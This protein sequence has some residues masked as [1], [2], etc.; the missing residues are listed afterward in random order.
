MK[1][2]LK[3]ILSSC[4]CIA[5]QLIPQER[6]PEYF[7]KL[8]EIPKQAPSARGLSRIRALAPGTQ[9]VIPSHIPALFPAIP[10]DFAT[11]TLLSPIDRKQATTVQ[12]DIDPP[13]EKGPPEISH[14]PTT[15]ATS[16][17][18]FDSWYDACKS[19]TPNIKL[20][21][22]KPPQKQLVTKKELKLVLQSYNK[23]MTHQLSNAP[24][25]GQPPAPNSLFYVP[26]YPEKDFHNHMPFVQKIVVKPGT[27]I[28]VHGD[29]HGDILSPMAFLN[30]LKN[31]NYLDNNFK[32]IKENFMMLFLGDYT[33]RGN[34]GIENIYTILR[35]KIMNPDKVFL[36]RGNHED[37]SITS[38]YGFMKE[39]EKKYGNDAPEITK[40]IHRIYDFMPV[41]LYLGT[42]DATQDIINFLLCCHG[43]LEPGFYPQRLLLNPESIAYELLP[44][45]LNPEKSIKKLDNTLKE[46]ID[47]ALLKKFA[48]SRS[49]KN[50]YFNIGFMWN[51]FFVA[52]NHVLEYNSGRGWQ[53]GKDIT[54]NLLAAH[55]N[56]QA[57]IRG[58]L[59]AHQHGDLGTSEMMQS[60]YDTAN[61]TPTHKGISKLWKQEG[62]ADFN[63]NKLWDGIVATFS[64][65]PDNAHFNP[66]GKKLD[67]HAFG[68]LTTA[69]HFNDWTLQAIRLKFPQAILPIYT[70]D[71]LPSITQKHLSRQISQ[72]IPPPLKHDTI[73]VRDRG[74]NGKKAKEGHSV[75]IEDVIKEYKITQSKLMQDFIRIQNLLQTQP[76]SPTSQQLFMEKFIELNE[77]IKNQE[78]ILT[79]LGLTP[80]STQ[81]IA[82]EKKSNIAAQVKNLLN[83]LQEN[84]NK[85]ELFIQQNK[86]Q[87]AINE[88]EKNAQ[89]FEQLIQQIKQA[90]DANDMELLK[91]TMQELRKKITY[92]LRLQTDDFKN[93]SLAYEKHKGFP[94]TSD[95]Q[96][97]IPLYE[98]AI[99][100]YKKYV[101]EYKKYAAH[102]NKAIRE[103]EENLKKFDT[104]L[105][106]ASALLLEGKEQEVKNLIQ[107]HQS[108]LKIALENQR[109][110][111]I[112][113]GLSSTAPSTYSM[114]LYAPAFD[115]KTNINDYLKTAI[116]FYEQQAKN[117]KKKALP[118]QKEP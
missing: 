77:A 102:V 105:A 118:K 97:D 88:Y 52:P 86:F 74:D 101:E 104:L 32:I 91:N 8:Q 79:Q 66:E 116:I 49:I 63:T 64:V 70:R 42:P 21:V 31:Q 76:H 72:Q 35:L 53:F 98:Q 81:L 13:F 19:I 67:I 96:K 30:Y 4:I 113:A 112:A 71:I 47:N 17:P 87:V 24:W 2:L 73:V 99:N 34:Y 75:F 57:I 114:P 40:E 92:A 103:H 69:A 9:R 7:K 90:A 43:G 14:V 6:E 11:R 26:K 36:I 106:Q 50:N 56:P 48:Q 27:K 10:R 65:A 109:K 117:F 100:H 55:S 12:K 95:L 37:I 15:F 23:L 58:V 46:S 80:T 68:V 33:D 115:A 78:S 25:I 83:A 1:K 18:T 5:L 29:L 108:T 82:L 16:Y 84:T 94:L 54:K 20:G 44:L 39:L 38:R 111:F 51:D 45:T 60:I 59:R 62:N 89:T 41:A 22:N 93:I 110:D 107:Q 3:I 28:A 61:K 85:I